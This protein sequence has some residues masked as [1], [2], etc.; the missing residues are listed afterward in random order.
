MGRY[1]KSARAHGTAR[2]MEWPGKVRHRAA[3]SAALGPDVHTLEK[4]DPSVVRDG[5]DLELVSL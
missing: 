5:G 1:G 2:L 4:L 3:V